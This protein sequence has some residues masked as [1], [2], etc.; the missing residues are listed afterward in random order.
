MSRTVTKRYKKWSLK[1]PKSWFYIVF[2][3]GF[4]HV[5]RAPNRWKKKPKSKKKW[6]IKNTHK[7]N[8]LKLK[9]LGFCTYRVG[10]NSMSYQTKTVFKT[11]VLHVSL[12]N[13]ALTV[14]KQRFSKNAIEIV[15]KRWVYHYQ[16]IFENRRPNLRFGL[17]KGTQNDP[18]RPCQVYKIVPDRAREGL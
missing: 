9:I 1:I 7:M 12:K 16:N 4:E 15:V 10:K 6:T 14:V 5:W 11:C 18:D 3:N 13:D 2:Y 8:E 17:P